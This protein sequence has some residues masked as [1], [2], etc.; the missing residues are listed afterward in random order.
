M[1]MDGITY[2][3]VETENKVG[4]TDT[5]VTPGVKTYEGFTSPDTQTVNINGD[6]S[7]RQILL[8]E[9]QIQKFI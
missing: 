3:E 7:N 8:K 9:K 2:T 1:N 4:T 5:E 6:K